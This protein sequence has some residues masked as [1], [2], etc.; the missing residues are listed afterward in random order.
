MIYV[1]SIKAT[2][3]DQMVKTMIKNNKNAKNDNDKKQVSANK[4]RNKMLA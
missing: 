4:T 1:Y 3:Q 2:Q